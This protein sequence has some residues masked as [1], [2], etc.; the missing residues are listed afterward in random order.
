MRGDTTRSTREAVGDGANEAE[1]R[2][3]T[4][5]VIEMIDVSQ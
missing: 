1:T 2:S 5:N 4:V 3:Q